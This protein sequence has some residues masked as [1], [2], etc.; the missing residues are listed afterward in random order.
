MEDKESRYQLAE[1]L[2]ELAEHSSETEMRN[3]LSRMYYATYHLAR[4]LT[5]EKEHGNVQAA[6]KRFDAKSAGELRDL[7]RLRESA[8]Y[9][10]DFVIEEYES[11]E[12]FRRQF[13]EDMGRA[14]ILYER[15]RERVEEAR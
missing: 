5:G 10:P 9:D 2:R 15:L 6:L 11:L 7:Y 12:D 14:R 13:S 1:R 4:I 3:S 8:D